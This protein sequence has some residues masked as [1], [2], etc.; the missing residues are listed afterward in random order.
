MER[1]ALQV[2]HPHISIMAKIVPYK[3]SQDDEYEEIFDFGC[4]G[5]NRFFIV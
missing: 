2:K 1:R 3:Y 4:Y 5:N